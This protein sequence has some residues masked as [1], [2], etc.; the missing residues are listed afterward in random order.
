MG[1]ILFSTEGLQDS[2]VRIPDQYLFAE[3]DTEDFKIY[4]YYLDTMEN[5]R[6]SQ[7]G[8]F[9]VFNK[10]GVEIPKDKLKEMGFIFE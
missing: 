7:D 6:K 9:R 8:E 3:K 2:L 4:Q 1:E 5:F 10:Y